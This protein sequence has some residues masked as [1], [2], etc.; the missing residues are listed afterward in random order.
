MLQTWTMPAYSSRLWL[1]TQL[2]VY[3]F[4]SVLCYNQGLTPPTMVH[5]LISPFSPTIS[6][7]PAS[8][9]G[10][11]SVD[12]PIPSLP[13]FLF[14]WLLVR[15][16]FHLSLRHTPAEKWLGHL[17]SIS[18]PCVCVAC[19]RALSYLS[20]D[21]GIPSRMIRL[22][23]TFIVYRIAASMNLYGCI[24][25]ESPHRLF[26]YC[27][28]EREAM[29]SSPIHAEN[30]FWCKALGPLLLVL[31]FAPY[32]EENSLEFLNIYIRLS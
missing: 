17:I 7:L 16:V 14:P 5:F 32:W 3:I 30:L 29:S 4:T 6:I 21:S 28:Q 25:V 26:T 2:T 18:L 20:F 24:M 23:L 31:F 8:K 22:W 9:T 27:C 10:P 15:W 12:H 13:S 11:P 19:S 1:R